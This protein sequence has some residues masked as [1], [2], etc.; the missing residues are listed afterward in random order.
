MI[1]FV[2]L[3]SQSPQQ[4]P[5]A[6][7]LKARLIERLRKIYD[8]EIPVNI[9]DLGLIYEL[10]IQSNGDVR[11]RMTLTA[12]NCPVAQGFP[13]AR[14]GRAVAGGR[15]QRCDSGVGVGAALES[16]QYVGGGAVTARDV[17]KKRGKGWG[18][19]WMLQASTN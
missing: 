7:G 9:Y 5:E 14:A 2:K 19:G 1:D 12:P 11:V 16:R 10:N 15:R 3:I 6:D 18:T 4:A 13:G 17:V 8:P